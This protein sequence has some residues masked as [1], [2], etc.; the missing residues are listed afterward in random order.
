M[1]G[2]EFAERLL[3]VG[4][5]VPSRCGIAVIAGAWK[6]GR[7]GRKGWRARG[8]KWEVGRLATL[9]GS[10]A[11]KVAIARVIG[12]RTRASTR[13]LTEKISM[14]SATNMSQQLRRRKRD[15]GE[16]LPEPLKAWANQSRIAA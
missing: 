14:R 3:T 4:E 12:K 15:G 9:K 11:R 2:R 16:G 8:R 1:R 7:T 5:A 13:W 6:R 10:D